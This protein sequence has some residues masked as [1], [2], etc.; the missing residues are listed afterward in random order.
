MRTYFCVLALVL[1]LVPIRPWVAPLQRA[2]TGRPPGSTS[3]T[4]AGQGIDQPLDQQN[5]TMSW[6]LW[7]PNQYALADDGQAIWIG[8]SGGVVRYDKATGAY[9]RYTMLDGLP[10]TRVLAVAVAGAGNRW[11]GGDGGLSRLSQ[12]GRWTHFD[13]ANSGLRSDLVDGIAVGADGIL[14]LSHGLPAGSVS[15]RDPDGAWQWYPSRAALLWWMGWSGSGLAIAAGYIATTAIPGSRAIT[16]TRLTTAFV[17][18]P[19]RLMALW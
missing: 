6:Q 2:V 9:R 15:R 7:N 18:L 19:Q 16:S 3:P 8:A 14:W 13:S 11:F 10:H 1:S 12:D 4:Y 5:A 17:I